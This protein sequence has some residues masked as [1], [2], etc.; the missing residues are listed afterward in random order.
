MCFRHTAT[1]FDLYYIPGD[2][3]YFGETNV[4]RAKLFFSEK[5]IIMLDSP[6][7]SESFATNTE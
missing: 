5:K 6:E 4:N 2:S 7:G 1:I 3:L